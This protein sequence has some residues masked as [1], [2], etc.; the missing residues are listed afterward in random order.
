M[1]SLQHCLQ[2]ILKD[3]E[4]D[5]HNKETM[6]D[7]HMVEMVNGAYQYYNEN[8]YVNCENG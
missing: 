2:M 5:N 7:D 6:V 1:M 4:D 3:M 8:L